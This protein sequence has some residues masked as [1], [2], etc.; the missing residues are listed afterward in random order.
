LFDRVRNYLDARRELT[1]VLK[2]VGPEYV[3]V[4]VECEISLCDHESASAVELSTIRVIEKYLH[5]VSG[6]K[7][8]TGWNFGEE[9][10]RSDFFALIENVPGVNHVRDLR[11]IQRPDRPSTERSGHFVICP[12]SH[13]I[14]LSLEE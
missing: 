13:K 12:G 3:Q 7:H 4:D 11:L 2:L 10:Q 9:A 8:G 1:A 5:P 6:G 14:T